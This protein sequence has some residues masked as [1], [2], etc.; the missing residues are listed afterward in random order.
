MKIVTPIAASAVGAGITGVAA[1][2]IALSTAQAHLPALMA[3]LMKPV[4]HLLDKRVLLC[5]GTV[6]PASR[7]RAEDEAQ[8]WRQA[9]EAEHESPVVLVDLR[10]PPRA[11]TR[12]RARA[13]ALAEGVRA[14]HRRDFTIGPVRR[15]GPWL[16]TRESR[17]ADH[18]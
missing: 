12:T 7:G 5:T 6:D 2:L 11:G 16:R 15:T 1:G 3:R 13:A 8:I 17:P 10:V 18:R 9:I 14:D 4:P